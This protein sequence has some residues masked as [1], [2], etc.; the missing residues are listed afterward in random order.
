LQSDILNLI[1]AYYVDHP[2]LRETLLRHSR[3]VAAKA[4]AIA[5]QVSG[6]ALDLA[7]IE[8]GAWLHDI[9]I[10]LTQAP[11][12]GCRGP[13]PYITHGVRGREILER[14]GLPKHA[15]ICERHVAVGITAAEIQARRLPLP[16]RDMLP[17][18]PEEKIVCLADKFYSKS[19]PGPE[20]E[21]PLEQI[22][23]GLL[24]YGQPQLDRFNALLIEFGLEPKLED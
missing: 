2:S 3:S 11:G 18:T 13:H 22:R 6:M 21:K 1:S 10:Y 20:L 24:R 15:L 16:V 9:G 8:E 12:L 7:L 4:L 5:R 17:C 23:K 14:E 19:V